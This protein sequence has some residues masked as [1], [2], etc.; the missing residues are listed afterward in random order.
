MK[1]GSDPILEARV[2]T[3]L[4]AGEKGARQ[5]GSAKKGSD[6]IFPDSFDLIVIGAGINGASIAREAAVQGFDVLLLDQADF[7]GGTTSAS[8]RLIHGGLRYLEHGEIGLV[9]E[10]LREREALLAAAPHLVEPLGLYIP[11]YS[12]GRRP[13]WQIGV[14]LM[15][16]DWLSFGRS[17]P[18]HRRLSRRELLE[19]LPGL[20]SEGLVGGAFYYDAQITFPERLVIENVVAAVEHGARALSYARVTGIGTAGGAVTGV[21]WRDRHGA[22][23]AAT[24]RF[25]VNAAGPWVDSVL[26]MAGDDRPLIGGTKGSHLVVERFRDA[27]DAAIYTEAA[28]DGRPFFVI[29]WNGL[30]LIGTTDL[31]FQG[32]PGE[33]TISA[34]ELA[35]LVEETERLFPGSG[36]VA[37]H[38]LYTQAGVRPLPYEPGKDESS[39]TRRHLLHEHAVHR[40]YS[41]VGGKLTTHRALARQ[42]LERLRREE[43]GMGVGGS[44]P[45]RS[46]PSAEDAPLPGASAPGDRAALRAELEARFGTA[47]AGRLWHTY[48]DRAAE[49]LE[50]VRDR[51]EL[52][53][54]PVPGVTPLPAELVYALESEWATTLVDV[55]QRRCML[56]LGPDFGHEAAAASTEMLLRL[57]VWD[58]ARAEQE[59]EGY[60]VYAQRFTVRE[61]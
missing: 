44:A 17:L 1:M 21:E 10:S 27:P 3:C 59:L 18:G 37:P 33:A 40:L 16:Y 35:Y 49:V 38:V 48:G 36:G 25:V 60:R 30:Y 4:S 6:P 58:R 50:R 29:P 32:D 15:L 9:R 7:G 22:P 26:G 42:A 5:E 55:L 11:V 2:A 53:A 8:T 24:A 56:G 13:R 20:A 52:G 45:M 51:A 34:A 41:V 19:R 14:G 57:G 61:S 43:A 54:T 47:Q 12:G 46:A 31:R 28:S 23:G 39:V